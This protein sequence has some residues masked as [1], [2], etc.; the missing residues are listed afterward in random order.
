MCLHLYPMWIYLFHILC[1][2]EIALHILNHQAKFLSL[3]LLVYH[4]SILLHICFHLFGMISHNHQL[5]HPANYLHNKH[6]FFALNFLNH[7][8]YHYSIGHYILIHLK[9]PK[10]FGLSLLHWPLYLDSSG[11]TWIPLPCL[12]SLLLHSPRYIEPS[13]YLTCGFNL[14]EIPSSIFL[15][16]CWVFSISEFGY[17]IKYIIIFFKFLQYFELII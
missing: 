14:T 4:S 6:H 5:F 11:N 10:P 1:H 7:L 16:F 17:N 15:Y 13:S 2:Y 12:L 8:A 3:F 9:F